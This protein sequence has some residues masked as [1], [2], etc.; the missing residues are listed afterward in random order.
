[1][2]TTRHLHHLPHLPLPVHAADTLITCHSN[3]QGRIHEAVSKRSIR[4]METRLQQASD[5]YIHAT[6]TKLGVFRDVIIPEDYDPLAPLHSTIKVRVS[7]IQDPVKKDLQRAEEERQLLRQAE[8]V[9]SPT[10]AHGRS[11][12][13]SGRRA[14][15]LSPRSDDGV[16]GKQTLDAT[17]WGAQQIG[18]TPYCHCIDKRT[19]EYVTKRADPMAN[20]QRESHVVDDHFAAPPA[21]PPP[22]FGKRVGG[23]VAKGG[24]RDLFDVLSSRW[25]GR[26]CWLLAVAAE[27][28]ATEASTVTLGHTHLW[29]AQL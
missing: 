14:G 19:G 6:N 26:Q 27:I 17:L 2:C 28:L 18:A 24:R 4:D 8:A 13:R 9:L 5:A 15:T 1:M 10:G 21:L 7:D 12:I 25:V 22:R 23:E 16:L 29:Q 20:A 11:M 3:F